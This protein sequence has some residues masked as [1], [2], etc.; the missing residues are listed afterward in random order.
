[1]MAFLLNNVMWLK[2]NSFPYDNAGFT[3]NVNTNQITFHTLN[4]SQEKF[5]IFT[6]YSWEIFSI[7][8]HWRQF[9]VI[10]IACC[11][12]AS[13]RVFAKC[14]ICVFGVNLAYVIL[15]ILLRFLLLINLHNGLIRSF[16]SSYKILRNVNFLYTIFPNVLSKCIKKGHVTFP[17]AMLQKVICFYCIAW[18]NSCKRF[19]IYGSFR[20]IDAFPLAVFSMSHF[21][22]PILKDKLQYLNT[23]FN[24]VSLFF[25]YAIGCVF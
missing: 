10:P 25:H 6:C 16:G 13:I 7:W 18:K 1:M 19:V 3:P 22:L 11:E 24:R 4:F 2:W 15:A 20:K 8:R 12:F 21:N 9:H 17:H 5:I 14:L 23:F